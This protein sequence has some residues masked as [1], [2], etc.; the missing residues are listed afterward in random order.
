MLAIV[1][2]VISSLGI[3][4]HYFDAEAAGFVQLYGNQISRAF[5]WTVG[6]AITWPLLEEMEQV[7]A[8]FYAIAASTP[9]RS[10]KPH[11]AG[12]KILRAFTIS[13]LKLLQQLNYAIT[14]PNHLASLLEPVTSEERAVLEKEQSNTQAGFDPLKRPLIL[15]L[16]HRLFKLSSNI[17]ETLLTISRADTVLL[18]SQDDWPLQE[19]VVVPYSK[20]VS[21]EPASM[22]TLLELGNCTFDVLR[23][24]VNRPAG[25]SIL[26]MEGVLTA[27][28]NLETVL[29]YAVTQ[30][31]MWL[32]KP[33]FE[34][35][36]MHGSESMTVDGGA[37]DEKMDGKEHRSHAR[38]SST[39]LAE[40][41]RR[42]MTGEIA[43]DLQALITKAKP[44]IE[45]SE[46]LLSMHNHAKLGDKPSH[47]A[48]YVGGTEGG[49]ILMMPR[50][51]HSLPQ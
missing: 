45:K 7:I 33:D 40:R 48:L 4:H 10:S 50:W 30:L 28:R 47:P 32:L 27:R 16:V 46:R 24:L 8:L 49:T 31:A 21:G 25:Q 42:G 39:S 51:P 20:V 11:P 43:A 26:P 15:Q 9:G 38:P 12:E 5:S 6:D 13:G 14:H 1:A 17:L 3:S 18:L 19:A 35:S 44:I 29:T 36:T 23:D 37:D 34:S 2:V 22:G 41:V